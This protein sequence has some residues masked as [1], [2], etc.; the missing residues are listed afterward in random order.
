M[1][2]ERVI[3]VG[4]T[5]ILTILYY[6]I[7]PLYDFKLRFKSKSRF[8]PV[9]LVIKSKFSTKTRFKSYINVGV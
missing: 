3:M 9:D 2:I 5:V 8:N 7:C 4:V 6:T 1:S